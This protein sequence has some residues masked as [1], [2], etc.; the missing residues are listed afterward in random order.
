M[1]PSSA[2]ATSRPL[3]FLRK[4][5]RKKDFLYLSVR[6]EVATFA[7]KVFTDIIAI[8]AFNVT[9]S[10]LYPVSFLCFRTVEGTPYRRWWT[11][12]IPTMKGSL[13]LRHCLRIE[14]G[15]SESKEDYSV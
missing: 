6:T 4:C 7:T 10:L 3:L 2:A 5:R 9:A 11:C 1:S 14:P 15:M 13:L 12:S 8:V